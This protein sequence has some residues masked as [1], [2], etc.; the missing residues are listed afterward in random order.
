MRHSTSPVYCASTVAVRISTNSL[1]STNN[2]QAFSGY[3]N[4]RSDLLALGL[5]IREFRPNPA[6]A[7]AVMQRYAELQREAPVFALHAKTL[8]IDGRTTFIGTHNLDPRSENLNQ[9]VGVV[10][11]DAAV[12]ADVLAAILADIRPENSWNPERD[13]PDRFVPLGKRVQVALWQ[14][15]PIKPLL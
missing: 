6:H 8:V 5:E 11:R 12:A 13:D 9:E 1:A 14:W 10:I 4:Q 3:R 15:L 2:L 7:R